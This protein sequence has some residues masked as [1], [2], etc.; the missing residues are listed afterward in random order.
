M[1]P[2]IK[3]I[4]VKLNGFVILHF[5]CI[6]FMKRSILQ[7]LY[8]LLLLINNVIEI[9]I[10]LQPVFLFIKIS[11]KIS[12]TIWSINITMSK[13]TQTT[14][15]IIIISL[16]M[17]IVHRFSINPLQIMVKIVIIE[18]IKIL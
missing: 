12:M 11:T 13:V 2:A 17:G 5:I 10:G 3:I 16:C 15:T 6:K 7:Q 1:V 14:T 8:N 18:L 4:M 9:I